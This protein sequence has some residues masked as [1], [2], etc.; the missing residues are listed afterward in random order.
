MF[1]IFGVNVPCLWQGTPKPYGILRTF[2]WG[3]KIRGYFLKNQNKAIL[4]LNGAI[5]LGS[6][7]IPDELVA[8][9]ELTSAGYNPVSGFRKSHYY[10][11]V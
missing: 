6:R 9:Q 1:T 4:K 8:Y 10:C 5:V 7:I 3:R 11:Q 2:D